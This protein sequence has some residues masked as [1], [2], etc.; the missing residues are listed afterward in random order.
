LGKLNKRSIKFKKRF[1]CTFGKVR[2]LTPCLSRRGRRKRKPAHV[3]ERSEWKK[4][5]AV[6]SCS[7]SGLRLLR[8]HLRAV[9]VATWLRW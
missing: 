2:G 5:P 9:F 6:A 4:H 3:S 7:P 1:I 8:S